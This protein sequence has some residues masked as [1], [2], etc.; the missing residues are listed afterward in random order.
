[1]V[2]VDLLG[3]LGACSHSF[4]TF[5][6]FCK[7]ASGGSFLDTATYMISCKQQSRMIFFMLFRGYCAYNI[8]AT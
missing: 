3:G 5:F 4:G 7:I 6:Y 1:M 2:D 8:V